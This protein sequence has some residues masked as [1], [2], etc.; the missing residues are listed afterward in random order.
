MI[1]SS[2]YKVQSYVDKTKIGIQDQLSFTI[3]I[4]GDSADEVDRPDL[5]QIKNFSLVGQNESQSS[6]YSIIN[7]KMSSEIKFKYIYYLQPEKTGIFVIPQIKVGIEKKS[8]RTKPIQIKVVDGTTSR[9]QSYAPQTRGNS[10]QSKTKQP[11]NFSDNIFAETVLNKKKAYLGEVVIANIV[12]YTR[13]NVT[14]IQYK[15]PPAYTQFWKEELYSAKNLEFEGAVRNG[16]NYNKI[17]LQT[18]ALIPTKSGKLEIPQVSF[19]VDIRTQSNDFFSFGTTKKYTITAKQKKLQVINLPTP[20]PSDFNGAIGRFTMQSELS[21]DQLKVGD[22]F[23]Y[24]IIISGTGNIKNFDYLELPEIENLRFIKPEIKTEIDNS[25]K[26][27]TGKKVMKYLVIPEEIGDYYIPEIKFSYFSPTQ[28]KYITL[29]SPPQKVVATQGKQINYSSG[30]AKNRVTAEGRDITFINTD[31][32]LKSFTN[33]F[34]S[35]L[36]WFIYILIILSI[37][38]SIFIAS[39]QEKLSKSKGLLRSIKADKILKKYLKQA[40]IYANLGKADFY[41]YAQTGLKNFV[42]DKL[43]IPRGTSSEELFAKMHGTEKYKSIADE[44]SEY[45][46]HCDQVRFMPGGFSKENISHDYKNLTELIKKI[47]K[48]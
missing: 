7:G 6:S 1:Y 40:T 47:S 44:F 4:S 41:T 35:L 48:R 24:T 9:V 10:S 15:D 19:D 25:Y 30:I 46:K 8:Y 26:N 22:S 36:Y 23:T 17:I 20:Q 42:S 31:I 21:N 11:S 3:E 45:Y 34:E 28:K 2:N 29:N 43:N 32:D 5:P 14:N 13:Y 33:P 12:L 38:I 16:I 27:I 39:K 18:I 37:P